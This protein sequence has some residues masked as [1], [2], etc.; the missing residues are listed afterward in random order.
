MR[1]FLESEKKQQ[2]SILWDRVF[3]R[4]AKTCGVGVRTVYQIE[5]EF[6]TSDVLCTPKKSYSM[7]RIQILLDDFNVEAIRRIVHE[8]YT[9][10]EYPTLDSL[11]SVV[12]SRGVF[13][14]GRTTL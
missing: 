5:S 1:K 11:L 14:G 7:S 9:K 8:F 3:N 13:T 4:T 12:K 2:R 6:K 10:K